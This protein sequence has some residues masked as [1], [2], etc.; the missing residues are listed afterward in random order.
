MSTTHNPSDALSREQLDAILAFLPIVERP[1]FVA[2]SWGGG[3]GQMPFWQPSAEA[4]ALLATLRA[5][6]FLVVFDWVA[7][8]AEA[9]RLTDGGAAA[10]AEADLPTLRR[11]LSAHI[12]AERFV[13]GTLAA[14][15]ADGQIVAVLRRLAA[16]RA[17]LD[18]A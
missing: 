6:G 7:W 1:G 3:A 9:R 16:I 2:G 11:L 10:L 14:R 12:R 18:A 15:F 17:E 13:E 4:A 5:T 8:A